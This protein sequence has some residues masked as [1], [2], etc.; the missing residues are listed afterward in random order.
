MSLLSN[1]YYSFPM[2]YSGPLPD[3]ATVV[4]RRSRAPTHAGGLFAIDRSY[5]LELGGYD[6]GLLAWGAE[7]FELSFKV[8][9]RPGPAAGFGSI[10][11]SAPV[12]GCLI[13]P[14]I[15]RQ[16]PV[17]VLLIAMPVPKRNICI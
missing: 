1:A 11:A 4:A 14:D 8:G 16:S 2:E 6:P 3:Q 12:T 5:F 7:N 17:V 15:G 13:R 10:V 9:P